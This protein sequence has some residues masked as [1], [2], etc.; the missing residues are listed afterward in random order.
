MTGIKTRF[1]TVVI[2]LIVVLVFAVIVIQQR[3]S[4]SSLAEFAFTR[5]P[6]TSLLQRIVQ[7]RDDV[8]RQ[9]NLLQV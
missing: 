6:N 4:L 5:S 8:S 2:S 1:I 7:Q 3:P 9:L